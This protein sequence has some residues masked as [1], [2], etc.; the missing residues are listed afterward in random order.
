[1]KKNQLTNTMPIVG[2]VGL[3]YLYTKNSDSNG[4]PSEQQQRPLLLRRL[5]QHLLIHKERL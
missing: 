1:M 4:T 2:A 5:I 3:V